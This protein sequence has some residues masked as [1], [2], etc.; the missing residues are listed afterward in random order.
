MVS[1]IRCGERKSLIPMTRALSEAL[2]TNILLL[3]DHT[4]VQL[5]VQP[6]PPFL[7][8][9]MIKHQVHPETPLNFKVP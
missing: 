6:L 5:R 2:E 8:M 3:A 4:E 1:M 9:Y 7:S